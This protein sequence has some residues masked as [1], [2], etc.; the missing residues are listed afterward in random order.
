LVVSSNGDLSECTQGQCTQKGTCSVN[1]YHDQ[2]DRQPPAEHGRRLAALPRPGGRGRANAELRVA[3]AE[4]EGRPYFALRVWEQDQEGRWWPC[5]GKGVSVRLSEARAVAA[6]ITQALTL[7]GD[8][9]DQRPARADQGRGPARGGDQ[10][11]PTAREQA[12][13]SGA[14][15]S[16][17]R[18][19]YSQE[20]SDSF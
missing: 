17:P 18:A 3:L 9:G 15:P 4:F 2:G 12:R 13:F 14:D 10:R 8:Q 16:L 5:K 7:A 1:D 6:A 19:T 20:F 11:Q